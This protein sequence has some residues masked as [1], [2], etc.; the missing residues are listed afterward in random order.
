M[1]ADDR[2]DHQSPP[3]DSF[4]RFL[5]FAAPLSTIVCA[6]TILTALSQSSGSLHLLAF[7]GWPIASILLYF[8]F[9]TQNTIE[10]CVVLVIYAGLIFLLSRFAPD[11][12]I[13][14][15]AVSCLTA[16]AATRVHRKFC[17]RKPWIE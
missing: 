17:D 10:G 1:D 12:I 16:W 5:V 14:P 2:D 15:G 13:Y 6:V 4:R 3:P 9:W 11:H 7:I 8:V